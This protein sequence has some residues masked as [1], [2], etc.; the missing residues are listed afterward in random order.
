M[1]TL[2]KVITLAVLTITIWG[3]VLGW[4][5]QAVFFM[6][7]DDLMLS[8][9]GWLAWVVSIVLGMMM[10]WR[11]LAYVGAAIAIY[12]AYDAIRRAFV[13]NL[14]D[15]RLA[16]PVGISKIVLSFIYTATWLEAL[17]PGGKTAT[18]RRENRQTALLIIG[19]LTLLF[20]KL[21]NGDEVKERRG[22]SQLIK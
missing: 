17:S 9:V 4:S 21:V 13:H 8:F 14:G 6:D 22:T 18:Q 3:A 2:W 7:I 10:N 15:W 11:W 19:L 12:F 20:I 1:E 16:L 5:R